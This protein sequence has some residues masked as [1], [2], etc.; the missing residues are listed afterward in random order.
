MDKKDANRA[1]FVSVFHPDQSDVL[2]AEYNKLENDNWTIKINGKRHHFPKDMLVEKLKK[3]PRF[4]DK[5][6]MKLWLTLRSYASWLKSTHV[7]YWHPEQDDYMR[8]CI[9]F[10]EDAGRV[11]NNKKVTLRELS[12]DLSKNPLLRDKTV[13]SIFKRLENRNACL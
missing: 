5:S 4:S 12:K 7:P 8:T 2:K 13:Q 9:L 6:Y 1:N 3:D 10:Y 11:M